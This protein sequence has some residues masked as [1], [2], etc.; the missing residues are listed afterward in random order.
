VSAARIDVQ[1][2][3]DFHRQMPVALKAAKAGI[4]LAWDLGWQLRRRPT[5]ASRQRT[6]RTSAFTNA[7]GSNGRL[8]S[9]SDRREAAM[10]GRSLLALNVAF[11]LARKPELD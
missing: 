8:G 10:T 9:I 7:T 11:L 2:H 4:R 6:W 1:T 5:G 3:S